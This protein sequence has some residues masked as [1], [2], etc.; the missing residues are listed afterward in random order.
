MTSALVSRL[1][2]GDE[3]AWEELYDSLAAAL[4]GYISRLGA[5]DP[6]DILGDVMVSIV[7]DI[8]RFQ[9]NDAE[10]RP[11][12]FRIAHNRVIDATRRQRSRPVEVTGDREFDQTSTVIPLAE[13][14]DLNEV[15]RL[16]SLLTEDQ[17]AVIW[18][19]FVADFSLAE[20]ADIT[21]RTTEAVAALTH[22]GLRTLRQHLD[23]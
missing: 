20:A 11:W 14:P 17:R 5:K 9:G 2:S 21:S 10:L 18:L 4:R 3:R 19:R 12:A 22:R 13:V 23:T 6:D 7:R 8:H 16:L 15:S 1:R